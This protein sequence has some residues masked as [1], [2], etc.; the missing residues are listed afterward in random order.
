MNPQRMLNGVAWNPQSV[1]YF[2]FDRCMLLVR[3]L[4]D[5]LSDKYRTNNGQVS[6]QYMRAIWGADGDALR[7]I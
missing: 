6:D 5:N 1:L 3:Y 7:G 4:Y 2:L